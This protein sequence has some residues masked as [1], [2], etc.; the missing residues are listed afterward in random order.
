MT[1][2]GDPEP[3]VGIATGANRSAEKNNVIDT[4]AVL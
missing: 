2:P 3:I 4:M 1:T